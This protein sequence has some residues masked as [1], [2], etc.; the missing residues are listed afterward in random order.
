MSYI[1]VASRVSSPHFKRQSFYVPKVRYLGS[2]GRYDY[3]AF[4]N[5][6]PTVWGFETEAEAWAAV[7][8]HAR[9]NEPS[10]PF[11]FEE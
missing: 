8:L 4:L 5:E 6:M 3:Q 11:T 9:E 7:D 10:E 1:V 2:D